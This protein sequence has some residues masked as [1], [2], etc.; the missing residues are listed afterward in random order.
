M[1]G[2][3][4]DGGRCAWQVR[5]K[6]FTVNNSDLLDIYSCVALTQEPVY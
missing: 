4:R 3:N 2:G 1:S 5:N 6:I